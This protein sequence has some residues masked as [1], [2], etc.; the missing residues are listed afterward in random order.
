M[1]PVLY[2]EEIYDIVS[3]LIFPMSFYMTFKKKALTFG[4][5]EDHMGH[6]GHIQI[7]QWVKWVNKCDPLS[8]L[9]HTLIHKVKIV[10]ES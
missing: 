10:L 3:Y 4:S 6:M 1:G 5:Q 7:A 9:M 2:L 8:I